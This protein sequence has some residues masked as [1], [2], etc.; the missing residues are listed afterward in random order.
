MSDAPPIG[1]R[2]L[3]LIVVMGDVAIQ[4]L[5]GEKSCASNTSIAIP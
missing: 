4:G 2:F 5:H 3:H 1:L